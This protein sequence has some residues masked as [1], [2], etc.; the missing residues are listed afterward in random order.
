VNGLDGREDAMDGFELERQRTVG[1]IYAATARLYRR[2]P[3]LFAI[4]ALA[5]MAPYELAV[6]AIT[7]YGPLHVGREGV[8]TSLPLDL[9]RGSLIT[10]LISALH[11]HAVVSI[12]EHRKPR[13][14]SVA[15]RGLSALPVVA[16]AAV[17]SGIGIF[18]GYLALVIPGILLSLRWAVAA[19]A[20]SIEHGD[21]SAALAS[22]RG[23]TA[24]RYWHVFGLV[25]SGGLIVAAIR[26]GIRAIDLGSTSGGASVAVGIAFDTLAASFVALTLALLYFDLRARPG[27]SAQAP[28]EHP[29]LRDLD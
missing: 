19:Q 24:G 13:L 25:F 9:L 3:L 16:A 12:G 8:A 26:I 14:G 4:L 2:Y 22:S 18:F 27:Q 6:L 15:A 29:H 5:V 11:M 20:A 10:P 28:R 17:M 21:W 7:G 1:E 23:L